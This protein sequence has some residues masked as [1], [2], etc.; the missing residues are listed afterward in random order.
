LAHSNGSYCA[1]AR[2]NRDGRLDR[3]FGESG[4]VLSL[5]EGRNCGAVAILVTS[6]QTI[7]VVGSTGAPSAVLFRYLP[8]GTPDRR[9]G[10]DGVAEFFD[11]TGWGAALGCS[12]LRRPRRHQMAVAN[13]A[14]RCRKA[15]S[16][17]RQVRT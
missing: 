16:R 15:H 10:R 11:A 5:V 8:D 13:A 4:R 14:S 17:E 12:G 9:F 6:D 1:T 3:S 2:F 7:V